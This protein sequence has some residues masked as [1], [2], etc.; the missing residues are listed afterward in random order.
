MKSDISIETAV[1]I[2]KDAFIAAS[3]REIHTGDYLDIFVV[4]LKGIDAQQFDLRKD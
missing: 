2:V 4:T 1:G 3:E